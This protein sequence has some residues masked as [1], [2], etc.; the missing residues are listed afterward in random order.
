MA[1]NNKQPLADKAAV[2]TGSAVILPLTEEQAR[3]IDIN[4]CTWVAAS[5]GSGKTK[6]LIDRL[7]RLLLSG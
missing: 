6:V 3:A 2:V 1:K 5:A 4:Y 7:L